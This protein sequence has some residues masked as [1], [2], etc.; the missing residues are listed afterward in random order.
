MPTYKA[1]Y[2]CRLCG[3]VYADG[4]GVPV[5]IAEL[6]L[7][8]FNVGITGI[9]ADAPTMTKTHYCGG[10]YPGIGLGLAVFQGFKKED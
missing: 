3:E 8:Q 5:E 4:P 9:L 7:E 6:A 1:I 2:K 10:E